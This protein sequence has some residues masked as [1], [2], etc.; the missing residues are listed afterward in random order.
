MTCSFSIRSARSG[1]WSNGWSS[2]APASPVAQTQSLFQQPAK[3]RWRMTRCR[4]V[5][6][7]F[8]NS[9]GPE[10]A[11]DRL[12]QPKGVGLNAFR[13]MALWRERPYCSR[14]LLEK[15]FRISTF[16]WNMGAGKVRAGPSVRHLPASPRDL[17]AYRRSCA[18]VSRLVT[19]TSIVI[20][21]RISAQLRR[22]GLRRGQIVGLIARR[23]I[24]ATA[25][26]LGILK[27]GGAYLPLDISYPPELL[28]Y[29]C[30]DSGLSLTLVEQALS[31]KCRDF[32]FL[33]RRDSAIL[34]FLTG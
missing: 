28:R 13:A 1:S 5:A 30:R 29:I 17:P 4:R 2:V 16:A 19:P 21:T 3:A 15:G 23:S 18:T 12:P 24:E 34:D 10:R 14:T 27:A 32:K 6:G 22:A 20:S 8:S 7:N 25:A 11:L 26:I 9:I 33:E 31:Q